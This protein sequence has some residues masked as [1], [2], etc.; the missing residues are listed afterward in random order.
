M[1]Q[2]PLLRCSVLLYYI[3]DRTQF[4]G[5][6]AEQRRRVLT[7]IGEA[8]TAGV[9]YIQLRE[10]D[11]PARELEQ[12]AREAIK[13]V[14]ENSSATRL[15]INS[16]VDVAIACGADGVHLTSS[17]IPA[18]DARAIA[19]SCGRSTFLIGQSTHSVADLGLAY[20]HG[21]DLAAF[22]P[23]F[24][25]VTAPARE[26][27]GLEEL[28]RAC[29]NFA[30]KSALPDGAAFQVFALGGVSLENARE[31]IRAGATG[32]AAIRLFQDGNVAETV[33]ALRGQSR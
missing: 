10:K 32:I 27:I 25:K 8:A 23:V 1:F 14:R 17:D 11:L 16:R 9:D 21:A 5:G 6:E 26:G 3:T 20:S 13:L 19:S 18:S 7:R 29:A 24:G 4:P 31:C 28:R 30:S 15:L 2:F 22:G 12:L 33:A